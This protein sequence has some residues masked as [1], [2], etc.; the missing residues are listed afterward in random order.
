MTVIAWDGTTLAADKRTNFGNSFATTTKIHRIGKS[1]VGYS[2][3]SSIGCELMAWA[4]AGFLAEDFPTACRDKIFS[5]LVI[6]AKSILYFCS[7][8]YP[9]SIEECMYTIGSGCDY[10]TAAMYC[11]K[12]AVEAVEI[13]CLF[14][15]NCGNGIDML[16]LH[17]KTL[18]ER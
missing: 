9:I 2:G 7:G 3:E 15:P 10:A 18:D 16:R 1:L 12:T 14:D 11:G 8:P 17:K 5:L 13:A 6:N 4:K